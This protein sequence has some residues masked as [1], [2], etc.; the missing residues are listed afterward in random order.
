MLEHHRRVRHLAQCNY[1]PVPARCQSI[2]DR[3]ERGD[4]T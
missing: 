4:V 3:L 1:D 2:D